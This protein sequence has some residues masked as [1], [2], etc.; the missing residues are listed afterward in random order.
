MVRGEVSAWGVAFK[1]VEVHGSQTC[2]RQSR[3]V[4]RLH[5]RH[6]GRG[7]TLQTVTGGELCQ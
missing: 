3:Q 2:L 4:M 7:N 1:K 6:G 5:V